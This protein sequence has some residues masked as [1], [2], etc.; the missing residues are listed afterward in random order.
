MRKA[1]ASMLRRE[2]DTL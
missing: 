2:F 1:R